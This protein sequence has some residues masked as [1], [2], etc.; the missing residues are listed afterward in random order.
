[1]EMNKLAGGCE[2]WG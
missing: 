2:K 1:M